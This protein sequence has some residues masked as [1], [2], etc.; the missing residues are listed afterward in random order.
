M[1]SMKFNNILDDKREKITLTLL[2]QKSILKKQKMECHPI[3][4]PTTIRWWRQYEELKNHT[5]CCSSQM[6]TI[7]ASSVGKK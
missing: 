7:C 6:L 4:I 1:F 2:N 5:S 3:K